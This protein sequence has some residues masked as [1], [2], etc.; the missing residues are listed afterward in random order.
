MQAYALAQASKNSVG[1][2]FDWDKAAKLIKEQNPK[3]VSAGLGNDWE[4]TGGCIYRDGDPVMDDYT[5]LASVWA[6]PEL[7]MDGIIVDCFLPKDKSDY[8]AH[9]KWPESAL[10]ILKGEEIVFERMVDQETY[11]EESQ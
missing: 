3:E 11:I 5:Y 9:T 1:K 7:S 10:K 2:V 4:Y 6:T 8:D